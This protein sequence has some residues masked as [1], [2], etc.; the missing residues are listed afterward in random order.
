MPLHNPLNTHQ[1]SPMNKKKL[2]ERHK[3]M[4]KAYQGKTH[5]RY[6]GSHR[7]VDCKTLE[8]NSLMIDIIISSAA[9]QV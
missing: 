7:D 5:E 4:V 2:T 6:T 9:E 3:A 8:N 1:S